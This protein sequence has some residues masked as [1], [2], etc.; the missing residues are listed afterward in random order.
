MFFA[1]HAKDKKT[2]LKINNPKEGIKGSP[3]LRP[4]IE[5]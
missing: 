3:L 5:M 1:E 4:E 2:K